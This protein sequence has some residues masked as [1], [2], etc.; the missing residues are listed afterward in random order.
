MIEIRRN[1]QADVYEAHYTLEDAHEVARLFGTTTL[2]T[3]YRLACN[4]N[5]VRD[6]IQ[7]HHPETKVT[8]SQ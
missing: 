1:H 2:P 8:V 6:A 7:A 4:I 3:P 5:A